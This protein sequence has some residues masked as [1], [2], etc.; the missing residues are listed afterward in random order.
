MAFGMEQWNI[1]TELHSCGKHSG[2][3]SVQITPRRRA[4]SHGRVS[5]RASCFHY[6]PFV[7]WGDRTTG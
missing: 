2:I 4:Q 1:K 5:R 6:D 7:L 3:F